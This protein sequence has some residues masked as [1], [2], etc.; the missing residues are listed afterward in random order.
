[1]FLNSSTTGNYSVTGDLGKS[2]SATV[3]GR[4]NANG[5]LI[6]VNRT[7]TISNTLYDDAVSIATNT[8]PT[9]ETTGASPF[10]VF[11][12]N[13]PTEFY[14]GRMAA[15]SIGAGMDSTQVAA[16][17]TAMNALQTALGRA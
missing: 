17:S 1:L 11:A 15:Y 9:A 12:R 8:T 7:S 14:N 2:N 10:F 16:Y 5:G 13:G 4:A 6:L 3:G